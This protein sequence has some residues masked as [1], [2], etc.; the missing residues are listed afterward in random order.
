MINQNLKFISFFL[1]LFFSACSTENKKPNVII[2]YADDLGFGDVSAYNQGTLNTPNIDRIANNGIKFTNGHSSS[3]TCSPSRYALLTGSYPWRNSKA[4]IS[5]G[6]SMIIDTNQ[7][8]LP[9]MFKENNYSTGIVGKWHLGLG[10]G[11]I[12]YN[13]KISPGPNEIGFDYSYIMPDTQDRVP[14]VYIEDG[15]VKNLD[16][17]DPLYV[18][19]KSNFDNQPTGKKNPEMLTMK[20]HHGHFNSIING[21]SR[22][23]FMKGGKRAHWSDI[24]MADHFLNKAKS[25]IINNKNKSFFLFYSMQQPH[26]PRTPHPR[27]KGK[28]GMGPRGD[29]IIEADWCI[30]ELYK[31]LEDENLLEN[32]LIIISSD[33]GPV[34]NDGYFDDAVEKIGNHTPSGIYRG[35]KYSL[36]EAG[37]RVPFI[38][39]WKG[40]IKPKNSD[41]LIS[42]ID[43]FNSL[44]SIIKSE[45]KTSDSYDLSELLLKGVGKEREELILE[46]SGKTALKYQNWV[47]IPP[48]KGK[49]VST[50][51]NVELGRSNTFQLYNLKTDPSQKVN[52]ANQKKEKLTELIKIY[53]KVISN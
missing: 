51:T 17:N 40:V 50:Y 11:Q 19:F 9:K 4:K 36:F 20:W 16:K 24:D 1:I 52:L 35:G 2:I 10:D 44:S 25:Y 27:F 21:I 48:Y 38:S 32:T 15:Y 53:N 12:N 5:T 23:G 26:V 30:G 49:A 46:A 22:I 13:S 43:L 6:A 42:Q 7:K 39:Y 34:L 31:T 41:K 33:N 28:S 14:T 18:S 45:I 47:L 29:V 37:T 3:A 8:T